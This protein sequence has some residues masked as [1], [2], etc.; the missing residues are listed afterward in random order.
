MYSA[1]CNVFL[2]QSN[3]LNNCISPIY[4]DKAAAN[5]QIL[6]QDK[7]IVQIEGKDHCSC[8]DGFDGNIKGIG[9]W[10]VGGVEKEKEA[11]IGQTIKL[12][13]IKCMYK[14]LLDLY[15]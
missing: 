10:R 2:F 13:C 5:A 8:Y 3:K 1:H 4:S 15:F 14:K 7:I 11:T 9:Y 12:Y 6:P